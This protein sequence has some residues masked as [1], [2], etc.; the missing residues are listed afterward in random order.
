MK[1]TDN[2]AI[3]FPS[4]IEMQLTWFL[5]GRGGSNN[6]FLFFLKISSR[7]REIIV[8]TTTPMYPAG[9]VIDFKLR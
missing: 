7:I 5:S 4:S 8:S 3:S 9:S 2:H 1:L 6:W